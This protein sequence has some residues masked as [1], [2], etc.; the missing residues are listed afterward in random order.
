L[1]AHTGMKKPELYTLEGG[2]R[3]EE[4]QRLRKMKN[5]SKF[6]GEEGDRS[7]FVKGGG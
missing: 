6:G 3:I 7:G 5:R 4:K 2:K 1:K